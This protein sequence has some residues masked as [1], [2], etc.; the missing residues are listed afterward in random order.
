MGRHGRLSFCLVADLEAA[1]PLGH[2]LGHDLLHVRP[3]L[4][5]NV[6]T[7]YIADEFFQLGKA[8]P[9]EFF[10]EYFV[11]GIE[12]QSGSAFRAAEELLRLDVGRMWKL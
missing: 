4:R 5:Q 11:G 10:S 9:A 3:G 12:S 1:L 7:K 6:A 2:A 8:C